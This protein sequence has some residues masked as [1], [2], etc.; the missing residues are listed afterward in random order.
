ME[1]IFLKSY[2]SVSLK[3]HNLLNHKREFL[4]NCLDFRNLSVFDE[5][6]Q[7]SNWF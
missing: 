4:L 1:N 5:S 7:L 2:D 3:D 6:V